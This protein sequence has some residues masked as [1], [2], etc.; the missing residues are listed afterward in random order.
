MNQARN[1]TN[2]IN[3][4]SFLLFALQLAGIARAS[5][6]AVCQKGELLGFVP[7]AEQVQQHRQFAL[8]I[9]S[10][11]FGTKLNSYGGGLELTLRINTFGEVVCYAL[12][13]RFGEAQALNDQRR[14]V[15]REF[16]NWHY[17]PFL[18]SGQAVAAVVTENVAEQETPQARKQA[19]DVPLAQVH[20]GL[21]RSGCY[22]WCPSY[23]V[24]LYG[25][26]HA[27]YVGRDFVDVVGEHR[28]SV[29]P[30]AVAKLMNSLL[31]K[32]LWSLR[33]TYRANISDNPTYT[34][35][36][37]LGD[38]THSI[39]DYVGQSVGM[40]AVVTQFEKEIDEAADS[41]SWIHLGHTAVGH[42]QHEGFA[43]ASVEGGTL[44]AR[45][46][47]NEYS[48]DDKAMLEVI[49]LGAPLDADI[50]DSEG[51]PRAKRSLF[52]LA[53][54]HQR[55]PLLDALIEKGALLSNGAPDRQ[56]IDGAFRAAIEGG[57]LSFAQKIWNAVGSE[58]HP[59]L[60][61]SDRGDQN[62][63][64]LQQSPVTL[65]LAK[66]A[67]EPKNWQALE[68]TKWLE[69]LG[70]DVRA[71]GADGTTLLHIA[72]KAGDARF[73]KYLLDSGVDPSTKGRYGPALGGTHSEDV[74]MMLLEA[75]TT[76]S[77]MD[78]KD[79][80][81]RKFAVEN[82]WGRVIAWLDEHAAARKTK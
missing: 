22:G 16:S 81:F 27:V 44:L 33:D 15:I 72:A 75:G 56:K 46:V 74:A 37:Q 43:F 48:H 64:P 4:A 70:C 8:P 39:E 5:D 54:E 66:D 79:W 2:Y 76:T 18:R 73:V 42:L 63:F 61:F 80:S 11:P 52:E 24:D 26:G 14:A 28:Y 58:A 77:S 12:T 68:I 13:N 82:H 69:G 3:R 25:D 40:P 10:Y 57:N 30:D 20:I 36:M 1:F 6:V 9:I 31:A 34:V 71:H 47:A 65:L 7:E 53:L 51:F 49:Q 67:Y 38:Q 59:S 19:P 17:A 29:A 55:G 50:S 62:E 60:T 23:S 45:A 32:D 35:T 78:D 41:E 21:R